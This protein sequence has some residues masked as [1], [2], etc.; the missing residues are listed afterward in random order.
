MRNQEFTHL[1]L[2]T[3]YSFLDSTI[4]IN[5]LMKKARELKMAAVAITDHGHMFG[6]MEFYES[7]IKH[8]IKPII[9]C[10]VYVAPG[11]RLEKTGRG[12]SEVAFH[13]VLLAEN[14]RGYKNLMKL[15]SLGYTEGFYFKP[16]VDKELFKVYGEGLIALSS[17]LKGEIPYLLS[18]AEKEKAYQIAEEY[19]TIFP[20]RRFFLEIQENGIK[21]QTIANKRLV[22]MAST[23]DI[24]LVATN[25]CHYLEKK[26][27]MGHEALLCVQTGMTMKDPYRMTFTID[28]FYVK[29]PEEMIK[30]F[31]YCPEA[32]KNTIEIAERCN[33]KLNSGHVDQMEKFRNRR[34]KGAIRDA[35]R[36]LDMPYTEIKQ[37]VSLIPKKSNI[38]IREAVE[39][40]PRLSELSESSPQIREL[41]EIAEALEGL[42]HGFAHYATNPIISDRPLVENMPL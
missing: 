23:L 29:S 42:I 33:L 34:A 10:E 6:V 26:D 5:D 36:V 22:E 25:D 30:A 2:H 37:I 1:H 38:T 3:H 14:E 41:L 39:I 21:E 40:E 27:A 20:D 11:S 15:V 28:Q 32:I 13:L 12:I 16:R 4:K 19:K 31:D 17:C 7:A 35:G 8:G 9:G 24:P 18:R